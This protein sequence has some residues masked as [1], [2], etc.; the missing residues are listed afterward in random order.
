M[1]NELKVVIT[2]D[3]GDAMLV[4]DRFQDSIKK[5][6]R[7][8]QDA[9]STLE[10]F[11]DGFAKSALAFG[12]AASLG[13]M[14]ANQMVQAIKGA[15]NAFPEAAA[16]TLAVARTFEGLAFQ[17]GESLDQLNVFDATMKL[18]GGS[19]EQLG[20]WLTGVT[21]SMKSNSEVFVAN[22]IAASQAALLQ[23]KPIDVMRASLSV[24]E[25]CTDKN[26]QLIL[27]QELLGRGAI[28]EIPQMRRFFDTLGEGQAAFDKYGRGIDP[29]ITEKMKAM[30][31]RSGELA[32]ALDALQ[33]QAALSYE[34]WDRFFAW[35]NQGFLHVAKFAMDAV[36]GA[37]YYTVHAFSKL[38]GLFNFSKP[39]QVNT[40]AHDADTSPASPSKQ[41][42]TKEEIDA[43][44]EAKKKAD[45]VAREAARKGAEAKKEAERKAAEAAKTSMEVQLN[46]QEQL[47]HL[48]AED[49]KTLDSTSIKQKQAQKDAEALA[50][51]QEDYHKIYTEV[52]KSNTP[53]S[54]DAA[55][56]AR[57]AAKKV[58]TDTLLQDQREADAAQIAED[59]A[60]KA[61]LKA[62]D[63]KAFENLK[64]SLAQQS[65][66]QGKMSRGQIE[67]RLKAATAKGGS[68]A[69]AA[70]QYM[71]E[72]HW[73]GTAAGGAE[74]GMRDFI[75]KGDGLFNEFRST[76][77][78]VMDQIQGGV[79]KS[80]QSIVEGT[81]KGG[82]AMRTL[83]KG[84]ES[85]IIGALA[86][87]AAQYLMTAAAGAA[88]GS[89]LTVANAAQTSSAEALAT[90]EIWASWAPLSLVGGEAAALAEIA[91][92]TGSIAGASKAPAVASG[93]GGAFAVG[94]LIDTPTLALMGEAGPE[95][96][97]PENDFQDWAHANQN[98]G[99][100]LASHASQVSSLNRAAGSYGSQALASNGGSVPG[101]MHNDFRGAVFAST[102]E[103]QRAFDKAINASNVRIGKAT[104]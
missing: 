44:R 56:Q 97:A 38:N 39:G 80:I 85:S 24:I 21:R 58:Y 26:R 51:L 87:M 17:T 15:A 14:A 92:M 5:T 27:T 76:T 100:N 18:T 6:A 31:R 23:M 91:V 104:S 22:G 66:I 81:A 68:D 52:E 69:H 64:K 103:G 2:G 54:Q 8:A 94:G 28:N 10:Q 93:T 1:A 61:A 78:G 75:A 55:A 74:A 95:L 57:V 67:E 16:H 9:G 46:L 73:N 70:L 60:T 63:D 65:E 53:G 32:I 71:V 72:A 89:T 48:R 4:L 12:S 86:K 20:D 49:T 98:L 41:P 47:N 83:A 45:E 19:I 11:G 43:E 99:Y 50:K 84:I 102:T 42:Q 35:M 79:A 59:A 77:L 82:Q 37:V 62:A 33:K 25:S 29:N 36:D 3:A 88:F 40:S 30:E 101:P 96:V 90:A 34:P 13:A 7:T